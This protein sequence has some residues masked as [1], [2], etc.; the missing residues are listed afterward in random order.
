MSQCSLCGGPVGSDGRCLECGLDNT[1][2]DKR[3]QLNTHNEK[4]TMLHQGDCETH[5]NQS[6]KQSEKRKKTVKKRHETGTVKK[7][8]S[9]LGRLVKWFLIFY[10]LYYVLIALFGIAQE[11][12]GDFSSVQFS[13]IEIAPLFSGQEE[14]GINLA[15]KI[16]VPSEKTTSESEEIAAVSW[17]TEDT[18]YL[19]QELLM[20][21]YTVG[22]DIPAGTYQIYCPAETAFLYWSDTEDGNTY[23]EC[24]YSVDE[25]EFYSEYSDDGTCP[26]EAY[27]RILE[28]K[29]GGML[30]VEDAAA[31]LSLI[32]IREDR[33]DLDIRPDQNLVETVSAEDGMTAGEDFEAGTY[34][35]VLKGDQASASITIY[36]EETDTNYYIFLAEDREKFLRFPFA[37]GTV[38]TL[39]TYG[40]DAE[41]IL[42]P[43]Y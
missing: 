8:R 17:D 29:Q 39:E 16:A 32:G 23:F 13:D 19:N 10:L 35:L 5:L 3:Y 15:E 28:L 40:A 31:G 2:N 12:V 11:A 26:Y 9:C 22:Y 33:N 37:Q 41:L 1:K 38:V 21:I 4:T 43:S 6:E 25:Q 42:V 36:E 20:G 34:D 14:Q 7:K 18:C 30:Y 27:S 24:L